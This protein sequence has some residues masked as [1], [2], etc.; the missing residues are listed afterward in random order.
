MVRGPLIGSDYESAFVSIAEQ[1]YGADE[2]V[3][4]LA[5]DSASRGQR[6]G[7]TL[8]M[9]ALYRI[10]RHGRELASAG[11]VVEAIDGAAVAFYER[12]GFP[13]LPKVPNRLFL[14]MATIEELFQDKERRQE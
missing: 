2:L 13:N 8:H 9:D 10:C 12:Y 6:H 5:V 14:P 1:S 11:A 3:G 7:E 4:R